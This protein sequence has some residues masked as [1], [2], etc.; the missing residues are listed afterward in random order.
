MKEIFG[1]LGVAFLVGSSIPYIYA[2]YKKRA[3]PHAFSWTLWALINAIVFA[4]QLSDGAGAG[5]W[6][7]GVTTIVNG[8]IAL[9]A[10]IYSKIGFT[11]GD[12]LVFLSALLA[13]PLWIVTK[14]PLWSVILVSF[15][16]TIAFIPTLRKSWNNPH[17]EVLMAFVLGMAGFACAILA[18]DNYS[19]T[20]WLYPGTVMV[21]NSVFILALVLRR[22]RLAR[23]AL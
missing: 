8:G 6:T 15:I 23:R 17:S 21:T 10:F 5:A 13:I 1:I 2:L 19:V 7:A 4:A 3:R 9:H 20:N 22:K 16:D 11:R 14:D 18:L 12:W